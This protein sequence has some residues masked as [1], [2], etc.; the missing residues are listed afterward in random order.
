VTRDAPSFVLAW[1]QALPRPAAAVLLDRT[2]ELF[3]LEITPEEFVAAMAAT[4]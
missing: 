1:D 2:R 4:A 3:Q